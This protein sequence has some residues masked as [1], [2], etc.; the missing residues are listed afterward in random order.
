MPMMTGYMLGRYMSGGTAM[1]GVQPLF[2]GPAQ[3]QP[4]GADRYFRTGG[5]ESVRV[6]PG[7]RISDPPQSVRRGFAASAKPFT[8]RTVTG[9]RGG[10]G[11]ASRFGS[12]GS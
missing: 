3:P 9:S 6:N 5:G 4:G 8:A 11:G 2:R 7:G 1:Q 10:F 12:V